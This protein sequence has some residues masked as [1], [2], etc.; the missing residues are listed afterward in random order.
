[1]FDLE[2]QRRIREKKTPLALTLAPETEKLSE[3][4]RKNFVDMLGDT[5]MAQAEAMRYHGT[6]LLDAAAD[7]LPAVV[8]RGDAYLAHGMMG[9]DVLANLLSA[10][11]A[12]GLY[13]LLDMNTAEPTR[14]AG[15]GADAITVCPYAGSDCLNA[16][17]MLPVA[18]VRT[19]NASGGQVQTL[20]AGDRALWLS[21]AEQMVRRG[22][23]LSVATGYSL[24]VR[25]V[26]RVCPNA[27]LLLPGCDGENA[28]P[29]FDELGHGALLT[30]STLQYAADPAAAIEAK[31]KELKQWV[32]VV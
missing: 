25:D 11:H 8:L 22:A 15:Y 18:A 29:A 28:V 21:L 7:K 2:L 16:G 30:D 32:T 9:A 26:R 19:A 20:L 13:V 23:A 3:R 4:V 5:P 12:K 14:W 31:I 24:D 6:S 27:F 1:M 17:E 10:A